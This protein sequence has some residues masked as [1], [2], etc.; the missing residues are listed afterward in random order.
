MPA[1]NYGFMGRAHPVLR[2]ALLEKYDVDCLVLEAQDFGRSMHAV[3]RNSWGQMAV[4]VRINGLN[5]VRDCFNQLRLAAASM[6]W[7]A[8]GFEY[9]AGEAYE[10]ELACWWAAIDPIDWSEA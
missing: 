2:I 10:S 1:F 9:S 6:R 3:L 8:L 5:N 4:A 7:K